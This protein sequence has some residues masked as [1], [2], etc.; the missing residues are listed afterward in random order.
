MK[1]MRLFLLTALLTLVGNA[2]A[3]ELIISDFTITTGEAKTISIELNNPT[4]DYIALEFWMRL[5]DGVRI[6]YEDEEYLMAELNASRSNRHELEVSEPNNDGVYHFLCY[7]GRN[8]IFKGKSGE[9]IS[10]TVQCDDD[11]VAGTY[12]ASVYDIILSDPNKVEV[13]FDNL[14]FDVTINNAGGDVLLGDAN[15]DGSV[16]ITDAVAVVNYI[17]TNGN[18]IGNF[19]FAAANVSEDEAIT[20]AD[21]IGIVNII[22]NSTQE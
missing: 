6:A 22:L 18:P 4:K 20:I 19:V 13:N 7:S 3:D 21:A 17:L 8:N 5:P 14:S 10:L 2:T 11:A 15:G 12:T 16:S 9:L 1:T